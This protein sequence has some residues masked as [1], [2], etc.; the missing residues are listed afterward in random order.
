[1]RST[2]MSSCNLHGE[3][4]AFVLW[5]SWVSFCQLTL[6]F[7]RW[8]DNI[9]NSMDVNLNR[10]WEI[11][12]EGEPGELQSTGSQRGGHAFAIG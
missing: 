7:M 3:A 9:T 10:L 1:M 6:Y 11:V 4:G 12:K 5:H 2:D 8:L